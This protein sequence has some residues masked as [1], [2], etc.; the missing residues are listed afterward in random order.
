ML[1]IQL[2]PF[3]S[4]TTPRLLL[5]PVTEAD[6]EAMLFLKSD[7]E[8]IRYIGKKRMETL[9]DARQDIARVNAL[10][11]PN[12]G[13]MWALCRP[14]EPA[15]MLG[16]MCMW[17]FSPVHHSAELGYMLHRTHWGQGLMSEAL[18]AAVRYGFDELGLHRLEAMLVPENTASARL[19]ERQ[20][21]QREGLLRE[22]CYFDGQFADTLLYGRLAKDA[23]RP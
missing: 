18:A 9:E 13:I 16:T 17:N 1:T 11:A 14:E 5:R 4:L 2:S 10:L 23:P 12:E 7:E 21:F 15:A 6:A 3:Q 20:G 22:S 8:M 19:L